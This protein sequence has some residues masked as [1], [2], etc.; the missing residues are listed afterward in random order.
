MSQTQQNQRAHA[1]QPGAWTRRRAA[2]SGAAILG[3]GILGACA[4]P[5][6]SSAP[7]PAAEAASISYVSDWSSGT[8]GEWIKAAVPKFMEENPKITVRVDNWAGEVTEVALTNA[9]GTLQD[10]MLGSNDAFIQL[11]RSGGMQD[12]TPVL[13]SGDLV[14]AKIPK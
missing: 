9:A 1:P 4:E 2:A 14:L 12:I 7:A 13:K 8:R 5:G 11:A 10:V 3:S 6:S